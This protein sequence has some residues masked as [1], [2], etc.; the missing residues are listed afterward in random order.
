[1]VLLTM[2]IAIVEAIEARD[3]LASSQ[4][5]EQDGEPSLE[6]PQADKPISHGQIVQLWSDL[7]D[8]DASKYSLE[9]LLRGSKVYIPP[10]PPK[11]EPVS[12]PF[13]SLQPSPILPY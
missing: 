12:P 5:P 11:P 10:P 7:K 8:H 9:S 1:M 6:A 4:N 3:K 2:T 13:I